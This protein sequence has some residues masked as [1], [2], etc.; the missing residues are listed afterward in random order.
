[1]TTTEEVERDAQIEQA[2]RDAGVATT[3]GVQDDYFGFDQTENVMFPDGKTYITIK[4]LNEGARKSYQNN[5]SRE[6]TV[7]RVSQN[8][9]LKVE[10]GE[11][12]HALLVQA[13][14]GWNFVRMNDRRSEKLPV[15]FNKQ[16]V[17]L[18]L[19]EANPKHVDMVDKAVRKMNP[20][21]RQDMTVEDIDA[22]IRDLEEQRVGLVREQEGKD[23]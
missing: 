23:S 1:M 3:E 13:I 12:R 19:T 5:Q 7:E 11:E 6:I 22:A 14:V 4:A 10:S 17:K 20:W 15:P 16:E 2:M 21:L 8:M 9:K 18:W